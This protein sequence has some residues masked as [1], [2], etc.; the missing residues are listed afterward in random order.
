VQTLSLS[1]IP[2][3][4]YLT[5]GG[6]KRKIGTKLSSEVSSLQECQGEEG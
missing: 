6:Y 2:L 1:E 4:R 5:T 3:I